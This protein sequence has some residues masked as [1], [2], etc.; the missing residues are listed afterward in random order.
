M[1][2][3]QWPLLH[4]L[5]SQFQNAVSSPSHL[6][7]VKVEVWSPTFGTY[8]PVMDLTKY[9]T[10]GSVS[11]DETAEVR[12]TLTLT[13][14]VPLDLIPANLGD[15]LHP[16][17][18]NE[19]H[20]WRGVNY[21]SAD[22]PD[23]EYAPL[24]VFRMTQ[25]E[26]TD[27]GQTVTLTVKGNDRASV[28]ARIGW[29]VPYSIHAGN[30]IAAAIQAAMETRYAG[31]QYNFTNV[32]FTYPATVFGASQI[33]GSGGTSDPMGDLITFAATAGC[34]LFFDPDG[35]C[36]LRQIVS[37]T[38]SLVVDS[39]HFV[40]GENCVVTSVGRELDETTTWN[41]VELFCNGTGSAQPFVVYAWDANP[42]STTYYLGPWGQVPYQITTTAIPAGNQSPEEALATAYVY[43]Y[44]Q[45]QLILGTFD[46]L[47]LSCAPNPALREGDS[48]QVTRE[49][50]KIDAS[51]VISGMT[52]PL[53]NLTEM[54]ITFRPRLDIS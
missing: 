39:V 34:E 15:L 30:S 37:P 43:A 1:T 22:E 11:V 36:T 19:L 9:V 18:A 6:W 53:D 42:G 38:T 26:A 16:G 35:V 7:A 13:L 5:S 31:L 44:G 45:L 21:G 54:S 10:E 48:I 20:V 25:P 17:S 14:S 46:N 2:S 23:I 3:Y 40:E 29:Q 47:T 50:L 52:I 32:P 33:A 41:G 8:Y 4:G 27:D 24:G 28:I 49:R 51:Y 12:R